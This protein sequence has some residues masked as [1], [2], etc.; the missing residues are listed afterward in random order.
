MLA[1]VAALLVIRV[2][3]LPSLTSCHLTGSANECDRLRFLACQKR[4][5]AGWSARREEPP[6]SRWVVPVRRRIVLEP[7]RH[8]R[9]DG[10]IS[11]K[12]ALCVQSVSERRKMHTRC[13]LLV[14]SLALVCCSIA[15]RAASPD[16]P[17]AGVPADRY[18]PVFSGT[19]SYRPVEP[20]PWGDANRRV[21]APPE[22]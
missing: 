21:G 13:L 11:A 14:S 18:R 20:L 16:D 4:C 12:R 1:A 6:R 8:Y 9:L 5:R 22:I 7:G 19:K 17:G 10:L 15:G 2:W 3:A